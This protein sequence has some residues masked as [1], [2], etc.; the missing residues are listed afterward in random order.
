MKAQERGAWTDGMMSLSL[1]QAFEYKAQ[2]EICFYK[3]NLSLGLEVNADT[4]KCS[5]PGAGG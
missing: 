4:E 3:G 2:V 1:R 5:C